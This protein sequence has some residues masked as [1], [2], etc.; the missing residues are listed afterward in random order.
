MFATGIVLIVLGVAIF[1]LPRLFPSK[2]PPS[3]SADHGG[4]AVGGDNNGP[5]NTVAIGTGK[6]APPSRTFDFVAGLCSIAGFLIA[7][8]DLVKK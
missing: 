1:S 7:L 6:A 2:R 4:V 3:V 8:W 5:I